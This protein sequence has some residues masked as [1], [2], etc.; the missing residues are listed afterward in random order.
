MNKI[1]TFIDSAIILC[2][3]SHVSWGWFSPQTG[4]QLAAISHTEVSVSCRSVAGP[5][6]MSCKV[7]L[8][9]SAGSGLIPQSENYFSR[10]SWTPSVERARLFLPTLS[11]TTH[12]AL[13]L[14][15]HHDQ[16]THRST[17]RTQ[18]HKPSHYHTQ[19]LGIQMH[20]RLW[21]IQPA[22]ESIKHQIVRNE[23]TYVSVGVC[24]W[25]AE[26]W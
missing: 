20:G 10:A 2:P 19:L 22:E 1:W 3:Y 9:G 7:V 8:M 13:L 6:A 26:Q 21:V 18:A 11:W 17:H 24:W 4:H 25:Q 12:N 5:F 23:H 14:T 16:Q 15:L